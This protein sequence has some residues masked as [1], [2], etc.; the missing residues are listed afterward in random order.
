M[1]DTPSKENSQQ[2]YTEDLPTQLVSD[3]GCRL[4]Y[5]HSG[6]DEIDKMPYIPES[7]LTTVEDYNTII[8]SIH[9][10]Q[11]TH[12]YAQINQEMLPLDFLCPNAIRIKLV[13]NR[14]TSYP[15]D[16]LGSLRKLK[17]IGIRGFNMSKGLPD[18][19]CSLSSLTKLLLASCQLRD[20]PERFKALSNLQILQIFEAN[21][22]NG[23]PEAISE[24]SM[25]KQLVLVQCN[26]RDIPMSLSKL[27]H[28]EKLEISLNKFTHLPKVIYKLNNLNE[29][30][31]SSNKELRQMEPDLLTLNN[32][33]Q[34][35]CVGCEL[36]KLPPY[37]VCQ[38]GLPAIR[39][40]FL[41][42][43]KVFF[44]LLKLSEMR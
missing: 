19:I 16:C 14:Q 34:L 30:D 2:V 11:I 39:K 28:L 5:R 43:N 23:L 1:G 38:Q 6:E 32:L 3:S 7:Q 9:P 40:C 27:Q 13:G 42:Q 22:A 21:F 24:L 44:L 10:Y 25:L 29:L 37:F 35:N 36:L 20:L 12:L 31:F 17:K 4:W 18:V 8:R 41:K 33:N 26:L 15:L